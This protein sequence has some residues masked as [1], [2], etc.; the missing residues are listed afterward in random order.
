MFKYMTLENGYILWNRYRIIKRLGN[1]SFGEIY[2]AEDLDKFNEKVVVKR[3]M[4]EMLHPRFL[5]KAKELF[6]R[7]A[8]A[9]YRLGKYPQTP[10]LK[11]HF[12]E[13]N[14]C[15]LVMEYVAAQNMSELELR[16][17]NILPEKEVIALLSDILEVVKIVHKHNLIHRAIKPD[18]LIR[19]SEN[20]QIVLIDFGS[21]TTVAFEESTKHNGTITG[22]PGYAAPEQLLGKSYFSSDIY[23]VGMI[24][25]QVLTGVLT[26]CFREDIQWQ[27][28]PPTTSEQLKQIIRKMTAYN[29]SERYQSAEEVLKALNEVSRELSFF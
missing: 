16:E 20:G 17:G 22:S 18:N 21:V 25:I 3:L 28:F 9:L 27:N 13:D 4:I 12:E 23:A 2:L 7:E 8:E 11:A 19:Q 10:D 1:G 5:D 26:F 15:F 24:G 29:A 6:R 14:N